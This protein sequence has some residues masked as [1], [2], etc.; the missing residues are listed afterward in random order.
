MARWVRAIRHGWVVKGDVPGPDVDEFAGATEVV[1][2]LA[3]HQGGGD[4][5]LA[6]QHPHRTPEALADGLSLAAALPAARHTLDRL[7]ASAYRPVH[8]VV[9]PYRVD[10]RDGVAVGVLGLVDSAA[11]DVHGASRVRHSEQVYREVVVERAAVLAGLGCA[12]SAAM[13]VPVGHGEQL[14]AA[15]LRSIAALGAPAV[16]M[17]DSGGRTHRLWL[18]GPGAEQDAALTA[19]ELGPLLVADGNHRVAAASTGDHSNLLAFVTGG[20]AL[21]I[22][23]IH[24]ALV[25]TGLTAEDLAGA[26]RRKGLTV[27]EVMHL[28]PPVLPGTV[29]VRAAGAGLLVELPALEPGE[30]VPR[31]DHGLVE[32]L[33]IG[34]ALGIDP[35]RPH[36][37]ALPAGHPAGPHVDA[38][39]QLAPVPFAD[40]LA[41]HEQG[42]RM[43]RK[44]TYFTPKP[45][46][47]LL[48]AD[49]TA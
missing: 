38:L 31:I 18:L 28:T 13:L 30:P 27:R 46:S 26:W 39:L 49:L 17:I 3:G 37:H 43:P 2:A 12:T 15:V 42:R 29:V 34:D 21:G 19:V 23:A 20:P 14:T 24:R 40:V 48:L 35:E 16:S 9:A 25:G 44:S 8:Q 7:R 47:G 32:R 41:V 1:A 45:R 36:L 22:G 6:V 10:G 4:T 11:V 5:L 33:L